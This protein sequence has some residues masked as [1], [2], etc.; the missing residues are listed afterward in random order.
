[1][2]GGDGWHSPA[3][4]HLNEIATKDSR[5]DVLQKTS[6]LRQ[7]QQQYREGTNDNTRP[8]QRRTTAAPTLAACNHSQGRSASER[9]SDPNNSH[10]KNNRNGDLPC[11]IAAGRSLSRHPS[12]PALASPACIH[13]RMPAACLSAAAS[14]K[15]WR[16]RAAFLLF[17]VPASTR[18]GGPCTPCPPPW[19]TCRSPPG[20]PRPCTAPTTASPAPPPSACGSM[21]RSPR[22]P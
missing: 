17:T 22:T 13:A 21:P 12:A 15:V 16:M 6:Q 11:S 14:I 5:P 20:T 1:M 4:Q 18:S 3:V 8:Q 10:D 7:G 9:D 19:P 2:A